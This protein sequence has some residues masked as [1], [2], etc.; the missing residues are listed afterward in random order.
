MPSD[1]YSTL[2]A[3]DHNRLERGVDYD[4]NLCGQRLF[5][6]KR[7]TL[8]SRIPTYKAFLNLLDDYEA[9]VDQPE[10]VTEKEQND[11][12]AFLNR[13]LETEVMKEAHAFLAEEGC[14]PEGKRGF[15]DMLYKMWFTSYTRT[16][17][18]RAQRSS[19]AFE[20]TFVGETRCGHVIGFHNWLRLYD[21]ERRGNIR[22]KGCRCC[23]CDDRIILTIDFDWKGKS[24]TRDSFFVGTSPEFELALYTVCFLAG[25]GAKTEVELG[26]ERVTIAT[27]KLNGQIGSCYPI[28]QEQDLSDTE[29]DTEDESD[30]NLSAE[31]LDFLEYLEDQNIGPEMGKRRLKGIYEDDYTESCGRRS[32]TPFSQVLFTLKKEGKVEVHINNDGVDIVTILEH[33]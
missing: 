24:K 27:Y 4:V 5:T 23:D 32:R 30:D 18:D 22:H 15:K 11:A 21:E 8:E 31:G 16:H 2:W 9:D 29:S 20:H 19:S 17:N 3:L 33:T 6:L 7:R 28:L 25:D 13:C 12:R 1:I 10:E 14:A 26:G